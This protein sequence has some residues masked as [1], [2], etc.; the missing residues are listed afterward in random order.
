MTHRLR[1]TGSEAL[2]LWLRWELAGEMALQIRTSASLPE[3][4][5]LILSTH[6]VAYKQLLLL[7]QGI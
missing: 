7:L 1:T 2:L 3:D 6:M 4:P 5:D